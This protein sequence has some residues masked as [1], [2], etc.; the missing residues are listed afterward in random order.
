M[1]DD[2]SFAGI[3][4]DDPKRDVVWTEYDSLK[5]RMDDARLITAAPDLLAAC[6]LA[7]EAFESAHAIDWGI[8]KAA[9]SKAEK[10]EQD[11]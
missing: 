6:K 3:A 9:I 10:S 4:T 5:I 7:L 8:I 2:G 1:E 11:A